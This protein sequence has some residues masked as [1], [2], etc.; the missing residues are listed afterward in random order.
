[1]PVPLASDRLLGLA[2]AAAAAAPSIH[3][4]QPWQFA[5]TGDGRLELHGDIDRLLWVA[6]P[7]G[8]ALHLSCGAALLNLRLAIRAAGCRPVVWLLPSLTTQPALLALVK[9]EP[10]RHA[11][12]AERRLIAAIPHRHTNRAPFSGRLIPESVQTALEQA[13]AS[14][15]TTLCMLDARDTG[16]VL[17]QA[18]AANASLAA[19]AGHRAELQQWII[20]GQPG[21]AWRRE[22]RQRRDGIPA[23]AVAFQPRHEPAPVRDYRY[24]LPPARPAAGPPPPRWRARQ[25]SAG[26]RLAWEPRAVSYERLPQLAALLT[27]HDEPGDWLRAGQA[28]QRVLLTATAHG[29]S[30]SFLYHPVELHDMGAGRSWWPWPGIPQM[31]I[32]FGYARAAAPAPRRPVSDILVSAS[33]GTCT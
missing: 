26:Q 15:F 24:A 19:N 21:G 3:N 22:D 13:A 20:A 1:M 16:V 29:L 5:I 32:R 2:V 10:A 31:I 7:R 28:L 30:A 14:E 6:D 33:P 9:P 17:R 18:A 11:T 12:L 23:A 4:T 25:R 8:R 27:S